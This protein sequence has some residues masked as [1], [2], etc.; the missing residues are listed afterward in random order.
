M[1]STVRD[2]AALCV[3]PASS[4]TLRSCFSQAR[5]AAPPAAASAQTTLPPDVEALSEAEAVA[6]LRA[7]GHPATLFG[8]GT[9][10]RLLRLHVVQR[11]IAPRVQDDLGEGQQANEKQRALRELEQAAKVRGRVTLIASR[12]AL[13]RLPLQQTKRVDHKAR[14]AAAEAAR[15]AE[16]AK[17]AEAEPQSAEDATAAA[18]KAAAAA[19]A[20]QRAEAA[21]PYPD[22]VALHFRRLMEEWEAETAARAEAEPA[23]A[24]SL[25]GRNAISTCKLTRE[26]IRPLFKLLK[27]REVPGDIE[28]ALWCIVK[29]MNARN[30]REAGDLYVRVAIGNA[31]WPI[32]VT[33][34]G[35]HERSAREKISAQSTAHVMQDEQTRKYLQSVKRLITFA[36]RRYPTA[37]SLSL[38]F[39]SGFNGSDKQA[40]LE[41]TAAAE[42]GGSGAAPG[43]PRLMIEAARPGALPAGMQAQ[44]G[45]RAN[46]Q[47]TRTWKSI[48]RVRLAP[49]KP[50]ISAARIALAQALRRC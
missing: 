46:D 21:M 22:R 28:R 12:P 7:L 3:A 42:A 50:P 9:R 27:R 30:Y 5:D 19:L 18:F 2:V 20:Q 11:S 32:G 49:R 8:E 40:L 38:E 24:A 6:R 47:D 4:E 31:P 44:D 13:T 43:V 29:A 15:A 10:D 26:H 39:N 23:W 25:E 14:A 36:Q 34:V 41:A 48:M 37:P 33:M 16:A 35:I 1:P 45:W 17:A